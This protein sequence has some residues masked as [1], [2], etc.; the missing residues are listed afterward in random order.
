MN[1]YK[2]YHGDCLQA[3]SEIE[4]NSIDL[5]LADPPYGIGKADWDVF[6][7]QFTVKWISECNRVLKYMGSMWITLGWQTVSETKIICG[8]INDLRLKN[9]IIWYRKDGWKG[10]KGFCQS[11]E[12]ILY[13]YKDFT[14][15][16]LFS[17]F[18]EYL[19]SKREEKG[20]S[21]KDINNKLG[22]A[23]TGGGNASMYMGNHEYTVLPNRVNYNKIKKIIDLGNRFDYLPFG[24]QVKFNP[25]G[26]W[27][28]VWVDIL[29]EKK[30]RRHPTQKPLKL[31]ERIIQCSTDKNGVVLDPFLGSGTTMEACQ[32]LRRSCIGMEKDEGYIKS[33]KTRCF[34]RKFL[35]REVEY[36][37]I[38][39][40]ENKTG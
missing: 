3:L 24:G 15:S 32:N 29:S 10:D 27:D 14:N 28:D 7:E 35:D 17:E 20:L 18:K 16:P 23:T 6:D 8:K 4:D 38:L 2:L 26:V 13:Y 33:I 22:L 11:H 9:W 34:G 36:D 21:L 1:F 37:F 12:H 25:V 40:K 30:N 19:N 31:F 5:V 39:K